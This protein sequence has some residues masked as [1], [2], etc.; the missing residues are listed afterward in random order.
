LGVQISALGDRSDFRHQQ[1]GVR[2]EISDIWDLRFQIWG[3]AQILGVRRKIPEER[4]HI[5]DFRGMW[6]FIEM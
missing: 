1:K 3:T 5:S 4:F 2:R 6:D